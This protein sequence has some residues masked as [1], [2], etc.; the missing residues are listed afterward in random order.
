M[1]LHLFNI[2]SSEMFIFQNLR[3]CMLKI[4]LYQDKII[5]ILKITIGNSYKNAI[6]NCLYDIYNYANMADIKL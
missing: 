1:F 2:F 3:E 4:F 6:N 5:K